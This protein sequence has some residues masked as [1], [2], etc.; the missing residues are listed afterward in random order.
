MSSHKTTETPPEKVALLK[1]GWN[2]ERDVSL[3]SAKGI[4][5]ALKKCGFEVLEI[6]VTRDIPT[7]IQEL[8]DFA[9]DVV[10]LNALHGRYVEDGIMQ[11]LMEMLGY[12]YTGSDV[13][14]SAIAFD[15]A[16]SRTIFETNGVMIPK[17]KTLPAS[18]FFAQKTPDFDYPFVAKPL[19][20]GSSVGVFIIHT[21]D[22]FKNAAGK[23]TFGETVLVEEYI[24][25]RELSVALKGDQPLGV[26]ELRPKEGFY[27]YAAK[28]TD[29][30][31]DH[32]MPADLPVDEYNLVMDMAQ[33]AVR[34]LGVSGVSRADIRYD[35]ARPQGAR[36]FALEIN[37]LPGMT[38]LSIV[39]EIAAHVGITYEQ[40]CNWM[41]KN[42]ICPQEKPL[43][44]GRP[45]DDVKR[46]LQKVRS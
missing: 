8:S 10:F 14:S 12:P 34:A 11:G 2:S 3:S 44:K 22:D 37:T 36:A 38:P 40:L 18:E 33:K 7:L 19:N 28:Y 39:P 17:G 24:P 1:G 6:D 21:L 41:V 32:L 46:P 45:K 31:T 15:K 23:W 25:G 20:E 30:L 5:P 9:P 42:P 43:L 27:D 35:D 4:F 29:G 16:Q 26:L 13:L